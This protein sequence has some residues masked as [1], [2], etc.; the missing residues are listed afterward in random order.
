MTAHNEQT[1]FTERQIFSQK[2]EAHFYVGSLATRR[3]LLLKNKRIFKNASITV[4]IAR[5]R[6]SRL[7][8][9][10]WMWAT[11]AVSRYNPI[12]AP[13]LSSWSNFALWR[14]QLATQMSDFTAVHLWFFSLFEVKDWCQQAHDNPHSEDEIA[15]LYARDHS[16]RSRVRARINRAVEVIHETSEST[17]SHTQHT[18]F[19]N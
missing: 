3:I 9:K 10:T 11:N 5:Y 14:S 7:N 17:N 18:L 2:N 8:G 6:C 15:A 16:T 12:A 19:I 13:A 1:T 4:N